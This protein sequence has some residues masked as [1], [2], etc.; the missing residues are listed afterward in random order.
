MF[1]FLHLH[2]TKLIQ[3][4]ECDNHMGYIN[5]ICQLLTIVLI[6]ITICIIITLSQSVLYTSSYYDACFSPKQFMPLPYQVFSKLMDTVPCLEQLR[7]LKSRLSISKNKARLSMRL[8][9]RIL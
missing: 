3:N 4:K 7:I 1:P 2:I 6:K 9:T 5:Y 8:P